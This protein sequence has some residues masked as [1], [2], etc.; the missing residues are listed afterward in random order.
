MGGQML[1]Q[2]VARELYARAEKARRTGNVAAADF[3]SAEAAALDAIAARPSVSDGRDPDSQVVPHSLAYEL[4]ARAV[5]ALTTGDLPVARFLMSEAATLDA[6]YAVRAR[7]LGVEDTRTVR[8]AATVRRTLLPFLAQEGFEP[9]NPGPGRSGTCLERKV[10]GVTHSLLLG[11]D[12]FG[13]ALGIH[14]AKHS[15][16]HDV[17]YFDWGKTGVLTGTLRYATQGELEAVCERWKDL[18]RSHVLPWFAAAP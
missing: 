1:P 5:R 11:P 15:G 10:A 13:G 8:V 17:R 7:F 18:I 14:A 16:H 9:V 2:A 4:Y 3:L 6:T 12:K